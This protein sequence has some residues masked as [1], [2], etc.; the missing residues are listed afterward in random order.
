MHEELEYVHFQYTCVE[1]CNVLLMYSVT[2][3]WTGLSQ[4]YHADVEVE[5]KK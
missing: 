2:A 5:I 1:Q 3:C 4:W